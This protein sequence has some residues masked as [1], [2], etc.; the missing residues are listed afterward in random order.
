MQK[1][2]KES[3]YNAYNSLQRALAP[4]FIASMD[5]MINS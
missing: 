1:L 4:Y 3:H 5:L 2:P